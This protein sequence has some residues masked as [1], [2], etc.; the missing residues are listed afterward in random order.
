MIVVDAS[1][2]IHLLLN[3]SLSGDIAETIRP[4]EESL[5]AP[6]L[7]DL[8]VL[9]VLRRYVLSE[10]ISKERGLEALQDFNDLGIHR[11]EHQALVGRVWS[12]RNNFTA[13]DAVYVALAEAL[14]ATLLTS[15]AAFANTAYH[16]ADVRVIS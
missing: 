7:I 15:D 3:T 1:V 8:E 5:H 10:Q 12:L 6:Q 13:Y 2:I 16:D 14:G 9:Q 11:H 4:P